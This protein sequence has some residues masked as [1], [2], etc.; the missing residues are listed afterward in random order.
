MCTNKRASGHTLGSLKVIL[1]AKS[2]IRAIH[3]WQAVENLVCQGTG[4]HEN[5]F[6]SS[7]KS[8]DDP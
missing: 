7:I 4:H 5:D 8:A 3:I 1:M 6:A 2:E